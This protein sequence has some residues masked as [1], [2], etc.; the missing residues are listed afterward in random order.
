M[1][2]CCFKNLLPFALL[3]P[4]AACFPEAP[5]PPATHQIGIKTDPRDA[6][7]LVAVP[8]DCPPH[9]LSVSDGFANQPLPSFGCATAR[10]L[11]RMID[12]P[13]DL[14]RGQ[15]IGRA[16]PYNA[17]AAQR[18][19]REDKVKDVSTATQS[20]GGGAE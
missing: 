17:V 14:E 9:E 8:P 1:P 3:L 2:R 20:S 13:A 5:L 11:A 18:R 6:N 10:N 12:N 19:Y 16:D 4:L 7:K 15:S